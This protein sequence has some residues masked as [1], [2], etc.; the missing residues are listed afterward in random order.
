MPE[1]FEFNMHVPGGR[2]GGR[3]RW[4]LSAF[5]TEFA[6]AASQNV[7]DCTR[8]EYG[9]MTPTQREALAKKLTAWDAGGG[10]FDRH[11]SALVVEGEFLG[12][13]G[14]IKERAR[15]AG[16]GLGVVHTTLADM[17]ASSAVRDVRVVLPLYEP[18]SVA[19]AAAA[20]ERVARGLG[21]SARARKSDERYV[22]PI[23]HK[24]GPCEVLLLD[25]LGMLRLLV[26]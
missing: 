1:T 22:W 26:S 17:G 20:C 25:G 5:L 6:V 23:G 4:E 24:D 18:T 7:L 16:W 19:K 2:H 8:A 11:V 10:L 12:T 15:A 21:V 3:K 13:V 9:A 14:E